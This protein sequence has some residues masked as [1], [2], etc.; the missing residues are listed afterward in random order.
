MSQ[1][2]LHYLI[3]VFICIKK[4]KGM[5]LQVKKFSL[6][7]EQ[8]CTGVKI[9]HNSLNAVLAKT[10]TIYCFINVLYAVL[11]KSGLF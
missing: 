3:V 4:R 7:L 2:E 5:P 1:Q 9:N 10:I 11:Y 6:V 8:I